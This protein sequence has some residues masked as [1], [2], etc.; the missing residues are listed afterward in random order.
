M[1]IPQKII[2]ADDHPLFRAGVKQTLES[3]EHFTV[4]DEAEDGKTALEK[5]RSHEPDIAVLD[6]RMPEMTGLEVASIICKEQLTTK[7]LL[8]TMFKNRNYFY[9]AVLNGVK[10]YIFKETALQNLIEAVNAVSRGDTFLSE[11][12]TFFTQAEEKEEMDSR[13]V[14]EA[15]NSLTAT[16]KKVLKKIAQWKS[17]FEIGAELFIS[18]RTVGSH[19]NHIS[20]KLNLHGQHSLIR[21]AIEN[22]ELF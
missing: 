6:I 2:I 5:I 14:T 11:S 13:L 3:V 4:I 7:T 1:P 17:N 21:F 10:G 8:L 22:K 12:L 18:P 9:Q 16:E 20:E 15:I 19:R